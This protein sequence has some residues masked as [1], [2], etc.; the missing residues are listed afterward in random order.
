MTHD[1]WNMTHSWL[2]YWCIWRWHAKKAKYVYLIQRILN[3]ILKKLVK[4]IYYLVNK[5]LRM[6]KSHIFW[7]HFQL[8]PNFKHF[9]VISA[10]SVYLHFWHFTVNSYWHISARRQLKN[11]IKHS[12]KIL[13]SVFF[14]QFRVNKTEIF[15]KHS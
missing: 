8:C 12:L 13:S 5:E 3:L 4:I 15:I 7:Q 14:I 9:L 1:I 11:S 10:W 6:S 2:T